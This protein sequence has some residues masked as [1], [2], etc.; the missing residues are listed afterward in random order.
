MGDFASYSGVLFVE[1][2]L[3]RVD[4]AIQ[5]D[6]PYES[7]S[8]YSEAWLAGWRNAEAEISASPDGALPQ[9]VTEGAAEPQELADARLSVAVLEQA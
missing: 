7:R 1:G 8:P 9:G 5:G 6:N 4:R 2:F 3:A